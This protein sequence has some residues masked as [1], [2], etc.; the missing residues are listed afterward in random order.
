M[1]K[2]FKSVPVYSVHYGAEWKPSLAHHSSN[3]DMASL[4]LSLVSLILSLSP[5][6]PNV[7]VFQ[8]TLL[9]CELKYFSPA[10][11]CE[12]CWVQQARCCTDDPMIKKPH[13]EPGIDKMGLPVSFDII[14]YNWEY[15]RQYYVHSWSFQQSH[16]G[17][18]VPFDRHWTFHYDFVGTHM[19]KQ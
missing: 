3:T 1:H 2:H 16:Q 7:K 5:F 6:E 12:S 18:E 19:T 13:L 17:P 11:K 14:P 9:T 10:E 4:S 15:R 8:S